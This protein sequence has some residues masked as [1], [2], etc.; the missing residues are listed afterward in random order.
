MTV[1]VFAGI[2]T[3][4]LIRKA[5]YY[6]KAALEAVSAHKDVVIEDNEDKED[7]SDM[8]DSLAEKPSICFYL[9]VTNSKGKVMP[10]PGDVFCI[11]DLLSLIAVAV[12]SL[13]VILWVE[14]NMV[15]HA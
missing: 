5:D 6:R 10:N 12:K 4:Y 1:D 2:L 8:S 13:I 3:K 7:A 14:R 11:Q 9:V 15:E